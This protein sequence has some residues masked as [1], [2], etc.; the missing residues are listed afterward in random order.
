MIIHI[1]TTCHQ[2]PSPS[3]VFH[4]LGMFYQWHP[5]MKAPFAGHQVCR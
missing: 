5:F 2:V 3:A 4:H 1:I